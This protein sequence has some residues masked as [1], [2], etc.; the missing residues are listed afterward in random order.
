MNEGLMPTSSHND[1]HLA[2]DIAQIA[3]DAHDERRQPG[4]N[5]GRDSKGE[6]KKW[7][8]VADGPARMANQC[9]APSPYILLSVF[10]NSCCIVRTDGVR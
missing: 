10:S 5:T 2:N 6:W 3:I 9:T 1:I 8:K 7:C 4:L